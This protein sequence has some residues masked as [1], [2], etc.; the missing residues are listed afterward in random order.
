MKLLIAIALAFSV[1]MPLRASAATEYVLIYTNYNPYWTEVVGGPF[2]SWQECNA[3]LVQEGYHPGGG[4]S[5]R[6]IFVPG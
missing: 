3:I 2:S 6:T 4:Y 1:L 5:C